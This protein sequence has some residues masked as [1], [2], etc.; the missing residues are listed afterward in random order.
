MACGHAMAYWS[1]KWGVISGVCFGPT[2]T[3][4]AVRKCGVKGAHK[5]IPSIDFLCTRYIFIWVI[6]WVILRVSFSDLPS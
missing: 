6:L 4:D 5:G 1:D 2:R 3:V